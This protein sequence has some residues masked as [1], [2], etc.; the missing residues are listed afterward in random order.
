MLCDALVRKEFD[1]G[2]SFAAQL[3]KRSSVK[4]VN[5]HQPH[6]IWHFTCGHLTDT[7]E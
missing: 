7:Q 6:K 3:T 5:T 1:V 2:K 4:S